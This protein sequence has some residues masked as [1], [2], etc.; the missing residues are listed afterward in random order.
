MLMWHISAGYYGE[1]NNKWRGQSGG[2]KV[3]PSQWE[4]AICICGNGEAE[5]NGREA[6]SFLLHPYKWPL[7]SKTTPS[8]LS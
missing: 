6:P 1:I 3:S 2:N 4:T 8:L 5:R 7:K